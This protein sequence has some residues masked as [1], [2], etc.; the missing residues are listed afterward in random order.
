MF[1]KPKPPSP[2]VAATGAA[3]TT[4]TRHPHVLSVTVVPDRWK[5]LGCKQNAEGK[6]AAFRCS[7]CKWNLH[8]K[9]VNTPVK[10]PR[11]AH[12]LSR[13][14]DPYGAVQTGYTCDVC[15]L[16]GT[17]DCFH[18]TTAGCEYDCHP[19]CLS[20]VTGGVAAK[21]A[22]LA[23][24]KRKLGDYFPWRETASPNKL[25]LTPVK[26]SRTPLPEYKQTDFI[27]RQLS[28]CNVP[29]P[30]ERIIAGYL[31]GSLDLNLSALI[32]ANFVEKVP[33]AFVEH[34]GKVFIPLKLTLTSTFSDV[35]KA[36][37]D[38]ESG[39]VA[40]FMH[41]TFRGRGHYYHLMELE[42][43]GKKYVEP[44]NTFFMYVPA[45][46]KSFGI[47]YAPQMMG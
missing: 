20:G 26:I 8:L 37:L 9:C 1:G 25:G 44:I 17:G 10:D 32:D 22:P 4:E 18:C 30:L 7:E 34:E 31:G 27:T 11:H 21:K 38:H 29:A 41:Y 24:P 39:M 33:E 14:V 45:E 28:V 15:S 6:T 5:C 16:A 19:E 42:K 36:V 12:P 3:S 46:A 2:S 23:L 47:E 35:E 40:I 13:V 43:Q